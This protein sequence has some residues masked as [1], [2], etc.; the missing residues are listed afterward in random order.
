MDNKPGDKKNN[1]LLLLN[2]ITEY[3]LT[4]LYGGDHNKALNRLNDVLEA[5]FSD[6]LNEDLARELVILRDRILWAVESAAVLPLIY[7]NEEKS[8]RQKGRV[9]GTGLAACSLQPYQKK[10]LE[11]FAANNGLQGK[12]VIEAG[13]DLELEV[14]R[15]LLLLGAG[16]VYAVNSLF[17][18]DRKSP[19]D[20]I[21][22]IRANLEAAPFGSEVADFILGIAVLEH[23]ENLAEFSR[24]CQRLL[25]ADGIC[26]LQGNPMW[27]S[28]LGH[29]T[30]L[31]K[32]PSGNKYYFTDKNPWEPWEHLCV[33]DR[34]EAENALAKKGLPAEDIGPLAWHLFKGS[35]ASRK[36]PAEIESVF[37][38]I[39]GQN[40]LITRF[41][42][43]VKP[44]AYFEKA[45]EKYPE[46]DL[47]CAEMW[48][49][50][51]KGAVKDGSY[52]KN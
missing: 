2:I 43:L 19:D 14:A 29:H 52:G 33:R 30:W 26:F 47:K 42:T 23:I 39:I 41:P 1:F 4:P 46:D 11:R 38:K 18:E 35:Q 5:S 40:C 12:I 6:K 25:K 44:N 13:A 21:T 37:K 3:I 15:A 48:V 20:R 36:S 34:N 17:R 50:F 49:E 27:T 16:H 28:P 10:L 7:G 9:D 22:I 31:S 24:A 32:T 8:A 51:G 45:R